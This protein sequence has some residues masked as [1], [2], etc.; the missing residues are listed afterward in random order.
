MGKAA[1]EGRGFKLTPEGGRTPEVWRGDVT[2]SEATEHEASRRGTHKEEGAGGVS[3]QG[4]RCRGRAGPREATHSNTI[5]CQGCGGGPGQHGGTVAGALVISGCF[6]E[7]ELQGRW[8]KQ[9][10]LKISQ[11][12]NQS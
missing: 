5:S 8:M 2:C 10:V 1:G 4:K 11:V 6:A 12:R 7:K 9:G 3:G